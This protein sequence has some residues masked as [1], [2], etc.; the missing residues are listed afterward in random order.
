M[1]RLVC[2]V[3]GEGEVRAVPALCMRILRQ[4]LNDSD[5]LVNEPAIR[6]PRGRLVNE[7]IKSPKR[8]CHSEGLHKAIMLARSQRADALLVLCDADDDSPIEWEPDAQKLVN[9][10]IQGGAVMAVREYETWLLFNHPEDQLASAGAPE[11]ERKRGAKE[12][13]AR[14][15]PG[16]LPSTHQLTETRRLDIARVRKRSD[17]FNKLVLLLARLSGITAPAR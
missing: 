6:H 1:K 2:I 5:W 4:Y 11:P 14:L 13:L 9:T 17:S 10:L 3:E 15:V 7:S 8:P 12:I 16:Y